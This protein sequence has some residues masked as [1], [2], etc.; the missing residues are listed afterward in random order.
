MAAIAKLWKPVINVTDLDQ[1]EQFWSAVSGLSPHGRHGQ[2]S[3]LDAEDPNERDGW[4]LLQ[5]VPS[6]QASVHSGTHL[7]FRVADVAEA[8]GSIEAIGGTVVRP[9]EFYAP[10]GRDLLEWAVMR[11]P[12]GNE[13]C[14]IRWPLD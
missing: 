13:F 1:G 3:I 10:E 8:A 12:F 9:P 11:D 6:G 7:D 4:I 14:I 2:F 5:L